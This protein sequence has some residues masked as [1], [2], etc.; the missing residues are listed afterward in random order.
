MT[1]V[2]ILNETLEHRV[3]QATLKLAES[4]A[5][6]RNLEVASALELERDRMMR[7]IHDGIGSNLITALTIAERKL[8]PLSTIAILRRS[9]TDLKIA[10]DSLEPIEG[11]VVSLLANMRHRLEPELSDAGLSFDWDVVDVPPLK[12]LDPVDALHILRMLQEA[13]GNTLLHA[14]SDCIYVRCGPAARNDLPSVEI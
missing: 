13:I 1:Q 10:V 14:Q 9:I 6:R 2:E 8:A 4:E 12:W 3:E 11:D 5:V 7:E